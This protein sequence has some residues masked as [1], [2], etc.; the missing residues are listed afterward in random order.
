MDEGE[1]RKEWIREKSIMVDKD[2]SKKM[3]KELAQ[4]SGRDI[5][6]HEKVEKVIRGERK[7]GG[8]YVCVCLDDHVKVC[9]CVYLQTRG[10]QA[11]KK[12][13]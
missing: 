8:V 3:T 1:G 4:A 12:I 7:G 5:R 11:K 10:P 2:K 13:K 6:N 9:V